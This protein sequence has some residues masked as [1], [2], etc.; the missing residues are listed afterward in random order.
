MNEVQTE[1]KRKIERLFALKSLAELLEDPVYERGL[2]L[3]LDLFAQRLIIAC[4]SV[5]ELEEAR[6]ILREAVGWTDKL[7]TGFGGDGLFTFEYYCADQP[8]LGIYL[9]MKIS[10]IPEGMIG[11]CKI[12][13]E[14]KPGTIAF[15]RC[16]VPV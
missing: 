3:R 13:E 2:Q 16:E 7:A 6:A 14:P 4:S 9:Q 8:H 10:D 12:V 1:I 15:L 5:E 11:T